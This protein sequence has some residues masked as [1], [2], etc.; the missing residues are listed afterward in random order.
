MDYFLARYYASAQGRFTSVDPEN[1]GASHDIPQ[2]WNGYSY[3]LNNPLR[4]VDPDGLRWAQVLG[5]NGVT[6]YRW[7]DHENKDA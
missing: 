4:F 5:E 6:I 3:S 7:F 1:T 2:G